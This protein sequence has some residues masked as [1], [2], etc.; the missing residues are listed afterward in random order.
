M[1]GAF[2]AGAV[3]GEE[4]AGRLVGKSG[5]GGRG[6]DAVVLNA[7]VDL[8][9]EGAEVGLGGVADV[10][11]EGGG[12]GELVAGAEGEDDGEFF[13]GPGGGG[14]GGVGLELE[15]DFAGGK[16]REGGEDAEGIAE[17]GAGGGELEAGAGLGGGV[18]EED[19]APEGLIFAAE[20][21]GEGGVA[22]AEEEVFGRGAEFG[23]DGAAA[24]GEEEGVLA[25]AKE[26]GGFDFA[27]GVDVADAR[28]AVD[29]DGA[30]ALGVEEPDLILGGIAV[31]EEPAAADVL[32]VELALGV[33]G[34]F[35]PG[36]EAVGAGGGVGGRVGG[37]VGEG[38]F[39]LEVGPL[40]GVGGEGRPGAGAFAA[41]EDPALDEL[42]L[43]RGGGWR[44]RG[45]FFAV[46]GQGAQ[47]E[48]S[49]GEPGKGRGH[50]RVRVKSGSEEASSSGLTQRRQVSLGGQGGGALWAHASGEGVI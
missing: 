44:G 26:D 1:S 47:G 2:D 13:G 6:D 5:V 17:A 8:A 15:G 11:G 38:E 21:V 35:F 36:G 4:E 20:N 40:D 12:V 19:G 34:D 16:G 33:G 31:G 27:V 28:A 43:W 32:A 9:L 29:A 24:A 42:A 30:V 46:Q 7:A 37:G 45:G 22:G 10:P 3:E 41:G 25:R 14:G 50:G 48:E 18:D 39:S 23:G 49:E